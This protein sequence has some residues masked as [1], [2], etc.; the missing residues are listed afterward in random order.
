VGL[1][2]LLHAALYALPDVTFAVEPRGL[3]I[4]DVNR[5]R[6]AFGHAREELAAMSLDALLDTPREELARF[7]MAA[8]GRPMEVGVRLKNRAI[9]HASA[10]A[11]ISAA[12]ASLP[13]VLVVLREAPEH[14]HVLEEVDRIRGVLS[15]VQEGLERLTEHRHAAAPPS[16]AG[17]PPVEAPA[18]WL[19]ELSLAQYVSL[20]VETERSPG[21]AHEVDARYGLSSE[22]ARVELHRQWNEKL[23]GDAALKTEW[24]ALYAQYRGWF[25]AQERAR[26]ESGVIP[27]PVAA[28]P[29]Q[30]EPPQPPAQPEAPR[31]ARAT[32]PSA[33]VQAATLP[34]TASVTP[35]R[36]TGAPATPPPARPPGPPPAP[37]P[38]AE[39]VRTTMAVGD[40]RFES[41]ALPFKPP[42][43][44][45]LTV[46]QYAAL[47]VELEAY[48]ERKTEILGM[49]GIYA[50][51]TWRA[52][53]SHWAG[54]LI[55][56]AALRQ[57]WMKLSTDLKTKLVRK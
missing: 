46:E 43:V 52:C 24:S 9:V 51:A 53:E 23:A 25:Q 31:T 13:C 5:P 15:S 34:F 3:R 56:D 47:G 12:A 45:D 36:P 17:E 57:R 14:A 33:G 20:C 10:G 4:V 37:P 39:N 35:T 44:P 30:P 26:G 38:P 11:S 1:S 32:A 48:P 22:A 41:D 19:P 28:A 42:D 8:D 16:S 21:R 50:D 2:E 7:V 29:T 27:A 40:M 49:Y 54:Q 55:A 6:E 18:V